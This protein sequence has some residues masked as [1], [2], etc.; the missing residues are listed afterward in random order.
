MHHISIYYAIESASLLY[1]IICNTNPYMFYTVRNIMLPWGSLEN[2]MAWN[3][4]YIQ[5][6]VRFS[7]VY[8][9]RYKIFFYRPNWITWW[10]KSSF[11]SIRLVITHLWTYFTHNMSVHCTF[12]RPYIVHRGWG[13]LYTTHWKTS[14]QRLRKRID[15]IAMYY[16][17]V[18]TI[19]VNKTV[20]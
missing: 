16:T 9:I 2:V 12:R 20:F 4:Y 15:A 1:L 19:A 11:S 3:V 10:H 14:L 5:T 8:V 18:V 13:Y 6:P 17:P 7:I